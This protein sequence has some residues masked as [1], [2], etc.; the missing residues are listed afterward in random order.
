MMLSKGK[1]FVELLSAEDLP[2]IDTYSPPPFRSTISEIVLDA[3]QTSCFPVTFQPF[4][5]S[6]SLQLLRTSRID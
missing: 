1:G 5:V 4:D 2:D 3:Y 6:G